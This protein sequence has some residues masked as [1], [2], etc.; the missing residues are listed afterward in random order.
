LSKISFSSSLGTGSRSPGQTPL[1]V[2]DLLWQGRGG[3][4]AQAIVFQALRLAFFCV[5]GAVICGTTNP[6]VL[7]ALGAQKRH[8]QYTT[9]FLKGFSSNWQIFHAQRVKSFGIKDCFRAC[10]FEQ[11]YFPAFFN[12]CF[13][14][15]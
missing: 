3:E 2:R 1:S 9:S 13:G 4:L 7:Q 11:S 5:V 10:W 6:L 8:Y 12:G 15:L 14:T